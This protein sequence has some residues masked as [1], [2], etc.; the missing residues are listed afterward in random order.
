MKDLNISSSLTNISDK[1]IE[2]A[3]EMPLEAHVGYI[4]PQKS[5]WQKLSGVV[6]SPVGVACVCAIVAF[7]VLSGIIF[8]GQNPPSPTP[9]AGIGGDTSSPQPEHDSNIHIDPD[10]TQPTDGDGENSPNQIPNKIPN[11][12][13]DKSF[14]FDFSFTIDEGGV[15]KRG[16]TYNIQTSITNIGSDIT[17]TGSSTEFFA[18]ATLIRHSGQTYIPEDLVGYEISAL[19]PISDDYVTKT[20][21]TGYKSLRTGVFHIPDSVPVGQYDLKI[22]YKNEY[23]IYEN[24]VSIYDEERFAFAYE[25]ID[26]FPDSHV[27]NVGGSI[28]ISASVTNLGDAFMVYEDHSDSFV[29]RVKF[30]CRATGYTIHA[31][32]SQSDDITTFE[33]AKGQVGKSFYFADIPED[34]DAG[35]YDL[36][37]S[38]SNESRTFYQVVEIIRWKES[39]KSE[40]NQEKHKANGYW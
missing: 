33:V 13:I 24:A 34:A 16:E 1:Y 7:G 30:V 17:Y 18:E 32:T 39:E 36:V 12:V 4:P 29:P 21:P 23:I 5:F 9:P 3:R 22:S 14:N 8:A 10:Y 26:P 27:F 40:T 37:L 15:F 28:Q 6:N 19:F 25:G 20:I 35:V 2:E 31:T 11:Q 38:Y